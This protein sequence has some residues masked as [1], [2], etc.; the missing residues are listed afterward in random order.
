MSVENLIAKADELGLDGVCLTEH[1]KPW[2]AED[3]YSTLN[4]NNVVTTI[5][6]GYIENI[7]INSFEQ[8]ADRGDFRGALDAPGLLNAFL[9]D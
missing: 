2:K 4:M 5:P 7:H 6:N 3:I 9:T 1:N 8:E